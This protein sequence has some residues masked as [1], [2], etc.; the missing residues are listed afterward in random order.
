MRNHRNLIIVTGVVL[1]LLSG[2][3]FGQSEPLD[4]DVVDVGATPGGIASAIT[5]ARLG[6]TVALIEYQRHVGGM[7][8]SGLGKSDVETHGAIQGIFREFIERVRTHYLETYGPDSEQVKACKDGYFYEPSVAEAIFTRMLADEPMIEVFTDHRL[9]EVGRSGHRVVS[10][11]AQ[12]RVTGT[13]LEFRAPVFIDATYEGDLA[14]Y[15]GVA[16]RV[17]RESRDE[18]DEAHAGVIYMDHTTR[19]FRPGSTGLGDDRL[20]AYTYRLCL[21]TD[22]ANQVAIEKPAGYDRAR[23]LG[24]FEDLRLERLDTAVKA[25]SIAPIPNQKTDVNMKPWPLGFPFAEENYGYV[26]AD[27]AQR[28]RYIENLRNITLGLVYFLQNDEELPAADRE[29]ARQYGLAKDEFTD[30]GN[31]PW[32]LYVREARRIVGEYTLTEHDLVLAPE[33]AR[34]PI[35]S[36]SIAT[37]E[38]P[39]DSFPTRKWEPGH[40]ELEG[41]ILMLKD[42]TKPYQ[43]PYR[44]IV[45]RGVDGLLVP[46]ALS[47]SH[48]AFSSVRM[49]PTW[50]TIGQAA[51]TAA[52][53][54]LTNKGALR[55]VDVDTLQ[56]MLLD[57]GQILSH[58]DDLT[59][60][61]P[62][63]RAM[64]F[65]GTKGFFTD[66]QARPN[67]PVTRG[68][69]ARWL[70]IVLSLRGKSVD[71][72]NMFATGW[73]D[74]AASSALHAD[75]TALAALDVIDPPAGAAFRPEDSVAAEEIGPWMERVEPTLSVAPDGPIGAALTTRGELCRALYE[76]LGG[77]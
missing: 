9:D 57:Q 66:Y 4:A 62:S 29:I 6:H 33:A 1:A 12:D 59:R 14:A 23:Y 39:I 77:V 72:R 47:A 21:S 43:I 20:V 42:I 15:A 34:A 37:G 71:A 30:N 52:H 24:Y 13:M 36:D 49:E 67:E 18:F 32:Q 17:G 73:S 25:L 58:F 27:W 16:C 76:M 2:W 8:A 41:Y 31:F 19:G 74:V 60:E 69:A 44:T 56:H 10:L 54:A 63:Y 70:R 7:S 75:L 45:P 11:R 40:N 26:E 38:F 68:D 46:V 61:D 35:H 64:Q 48:I 3:A 53:L 50:M 51:G 28:E 65:F 5:A 55:E 22:P